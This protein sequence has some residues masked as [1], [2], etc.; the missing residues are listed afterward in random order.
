[1]KV[2]PLATFCALSARLG[3]ALLVAA[4]VL[5]TLAGQVELAEHHADATL[6]AQGE[7]A[8]F[9]ARAADAVVGEDS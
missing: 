8:G 2:R 6:R 7:L 9:A 1:M 5:L 3:A 4:A